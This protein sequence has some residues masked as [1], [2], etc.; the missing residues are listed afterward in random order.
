MLPDPAD[1]IVAL[2]TAPGPGARAIVRVT[3]PKAF[4]VVTRTFSAAEPKPDRKGMSHHDEEGGEN[5]KEIAGSWIEVAQPKRNPNRKK[6]FQNIGDKDGVT[7]FFPQDAKSIGRADVT[8][9]VLSD[10]NAGD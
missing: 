10:I 9:A 1:T 5:S 2:S 6:T 3:G 8:A 7:I 4:A